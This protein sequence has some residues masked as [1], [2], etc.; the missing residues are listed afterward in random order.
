MPEDRTSF[1]SELTIVLKRHEDHILLSEGSRQLNGRALLAAVECWAAG[2][3]LAGVR[4][5]D[6]VAVQ[7]PKSIHLILLYLASLR[8]GAIYLPLN[9]GYTPVEIGYFLSD[10]EPA[11]FVCDPADVKT[12]APLCEAH[13]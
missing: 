2:L 4:Q 13:G 8:L 1:Y 3:H 6:R 10:A 9:A 5:G 11:L 12:F 7:S